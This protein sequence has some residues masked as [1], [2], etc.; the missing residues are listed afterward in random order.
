MGIEPTPEAWQASVL[1]LYYGR[2]AGK[3]LLQQPCQRYPY[4]AR[5]THAGKPFN[6]T[7]ATNAL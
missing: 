2:L 3:V 1:P 7:S 5:A 6:T 4:I